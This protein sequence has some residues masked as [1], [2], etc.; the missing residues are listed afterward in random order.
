MRAFLLF[1]ALLTG[2]LVVAAVLT[3]PAWLLVG[4][5]SVEPVH[6][7]M[8]RVAMLLALIGLIVLTRRL[9]LSNRAALGY[10]VPQGEFT[11][12]LA[13][14]WFAGAGLMLPLVGLLFALDIRQMK[15]GF[16]ANLVALLGSGILSGLI[17]ALIE[18]T[19][20]RGVL[21][22][23]VARTSGAVA[24]VVAPSLLYAALHFLGGKLRVPADEV[25]WIHGFTVLGN[26]F[27][28]YAE[29][30]TFVDSFLALFMLGVLLSLVR[31]RTG[32]IAA[33][34]GIHAAGVA[35]IAIVRRA[36]VV[37]AQAPYAELVGTYDGV[38]GWAALAWIVLITA[39]YA[40]W[41]GK[42]AKARATTRLA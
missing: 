14:G 38:I 21:F 32:S 23:A 11:E 20:F 4:T 39:A 28:R 17:V 15:P 10:G 22:T 19:F 37:D 12:Q 25:S 29:P 33:C 27:E 3:Y 1:L 31:L 30:L 16:D 24:A 8:N 41:S 13:A 36:T 6:R 2:A 34:I 35:T 9:G 26:L 42:R 40:Y 5:I 18:E 7:V